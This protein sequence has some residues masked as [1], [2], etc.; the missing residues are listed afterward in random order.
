MS[1]TKDNC[2]FQMVRRLRRHCCYVYYAWDKS[3]ME[4]TKHV[5]VTMS[6]HFNGISTRWLNDTHY[7]QEGLR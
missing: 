2:Q 3:L 7:R 1:W 5:T 4:T 6:I